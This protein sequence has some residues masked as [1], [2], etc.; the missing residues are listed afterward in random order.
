MPITTTIAV[1]LAGPILTADGC[2]EALTAG[3]FDFS[4][5]TG[6]TGDT[7]APSFGGASSASATNAFTIVVSWSAA[8]D[9][10]TPSSSIVYRIYRATSTGTQDFAS[11]T[12]TTS[13]GATSHTD[14]GLTSNL[15][16]YYVVRARDT[17]GNTDQNVIEVTAKTRISWSGDVWPVIQDNCRICHTGGSGA[18]AFVMTNATVT[19]NS[20]VGI[21]AICSGASPA[22]RVVPGSSIASFVYEK[23]SSLIPSCGSSMPPGA[24][25]LPVHQNKIP[26]RIDQDPPPNCE[27]TDA[28]HRQELSYNVCVS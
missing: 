20:W 12:A 17:S 10:V 14:T 5:T 24:V 22:T 21:A 16:Y 26:A 13:A 23:F 2:A 8:T 27:A 18:S 19:R 25:L 11:P 15:W 28:H 7:T 6:S 3:N 4:F 9:N 1:T